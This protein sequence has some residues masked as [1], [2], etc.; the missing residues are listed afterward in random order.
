MVSSLYLAWNYRNA[1]VLR[2]ANLNLGR[3][4]RNRTQELEQTLEQ[5]K[6]SQAQLI[7]AEKISA[8]GQLSA[9][10]AHEINNPISFIYGNV[11][12]SEQYTQDCLELLSLYEQ[13]YPSPAEDIQYFIE[14]IDLDFLKE[15]WI[16]LLSSMKTGTSRVKKIVESLR[17]FS[18]LDE[19]DYKAVN[20]NDGLDSTLLL[21]NHRLTP[22]NNLPSI[23]VVKN[24]CELPAVL[25]NP[26]ATNQVFMNILSNAI[27]AFSAGHPAPAITVTTK[28]EAERV[29]ITLADNGDGIP[30]EIQPKIFNPFFTSKPVG[31]GTGLGLTVS[32]QTIVESHKGLINVTSILGE[33]TEFRIQLPINGHKP[34]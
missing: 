29:V 26:G 30:E 2:K 25:C 3:L 18:R 13:Y 20:L 7:Q 9:G 31:K 27:E 34:D 12:A 8:L 33:G 22:A 6:K 17:N 16:K 14:E 4:V 32:Y 28:A 23:E 1:T 5:L 11:V 24:Y 15:D 21:L 10:I 19:A